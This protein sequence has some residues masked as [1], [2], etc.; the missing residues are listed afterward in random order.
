M[1]SIMQPLAIADTYKSQANTSMSRS[2][3]FSVQNKS[4]NKLLIRT[5]N[6]DPIEMFI[7][8]DP[9]VSPAPMVP[10]N[11][12]LIN[13]TRLFNLH[14]V[15]IAQFLT[16]D[17]LTVSLHFE[18][19]PLDRRVGYLFIYKF[20]KAPQLNSS[21]MKIDGWSLLCPNSKFSC[22]HF[23]TNSFLFV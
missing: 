11:A 12:T 9:Y 6:D 10:Q 13:S 3:S 23:T 21:T 15:N 18:I 16:N 19:R 2:I 1:K 22:Y 20:D 5:Y 17:N 4:S 8:R 14:S 7:P